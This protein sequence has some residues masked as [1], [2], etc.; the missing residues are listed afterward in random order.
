MKDVL[1]LAGDSGGSKTLLFL[2][3]EQGQI[4]SRVR[5]PGVAHMYEGEIN[6]RGLF[7]SMVQ[8]ILEQADVNSADID[9]VYLSLGGPNINEVRAAI[10][11]CIPNAKVNVDRE[12]NGNLL[13]ECASHFDFDVAVLAGTG[14][15]AVGELKKKRVFSGGWGPWYDD[16][17]SGYFIG[18]EGLKNVLLYIDNRGPET[19]LIR[20]FNELFGCINWD[21]FEERMA[22]KKKLFTLSRKE[23]AGFAPIVF[24]HFQ[25]KDT[26]SAQII[27]QA[28]QDLAII[29][30]SVIKKLPQVKRPVRIV[31]LGGLFNMGREMHVLFEKE[32]KKNCKNV[33]Y[34]ETPFDL[35]MGSCLMVLKKE[36]LT[37]SNSL[38]NRLV[39]SYSC[40][41]K[42]WE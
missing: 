16:L 3:T 1:F 28:I 24:R 4:L 25:K 21:S 41:N 11:S 40:F 8:E 42:K 6:V 12:A 20:E 39:K 26:L 17:G 10:E 5:G 29:V 23:V 36:G 30:V 31:V 33:I 7:T 34:I 19:S 22:F 15:V 2:L 35:A 13:M 9:S 14:T 32:L 38:L 27:H 37:I 18:K